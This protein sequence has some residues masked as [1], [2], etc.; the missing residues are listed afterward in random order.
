VPIPQ[1]D[2]SEQQAVPTMTIT[3]T[4]P[5]LVA[6]SGKPGDKPIQQRSP[7]A[8][9]TIIGTAE[10]A[11]IQPQYSGGT[12]S[13]F[14]R[15][16]VFPDLKTKTYQHFPNNLIGKLFFLGH[17]GLPYVA[18]ASVVNSLN[19]SVVW[20]AGHCVYTNSLG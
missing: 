6:H 17:D 3:P 8:A 16:R 14:T 9:Q 15:Y 13:A 10:R 1:R 4:T 5:K 7:A 19:L 11:G 18:S 2:I 12:S 20:T